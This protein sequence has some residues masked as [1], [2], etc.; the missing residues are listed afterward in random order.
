MPAALLAYLRARCNAP[1]LDYRA[2]PRRMTGGFDAAIFALDLE[3]APAAL[4]GP[5]VLRLFAR[6]DNP[7]RAQ[8]EGAVQSALAD[9]GYPAPRALVIETDPQALGG[10]FILMERLP[11]RVLAQGAEG[12]R[13]SRG[14]AALLRVLVRL[15]RAAKQMLALWVE[16]QRRL[17]AL[18]VDA[19]RRA[20]AAAGLDAE[21]FSFAAHLDRLAERIAATG[22]CALEPGLAWLQSH[23]PKASRP[24]VL[25]HGD[26]HPLNILSEEGRLTGVVDWS[27]L[28]I[29]DPAFDFGAGSAILATVPLDGPLQPIR[30]AAMNG[31]A[32]R[33]RRASG[34]QDDAALRY[35]QVFNALSQ[36][37]VVGLVR[38]QGKAVAGGYHTP[39]GV[40]NLT[41][42]IRKRCG[43]EI[44][45]GR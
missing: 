3:R 20:I 25:C 37:A 30:R 35:Y 41:G 17:H 4:S 29:A 26:L 13:E 18:P 21:S 10:A 27:Q 45:A 16:A 22:L 14:V 43:I 5:L 15:P 40:R 32:R 28:T 36:L 39:E 23:T 11:G 19:F 7:E 42:Y 44:E 31:L 8:R 38:A 12:L 2:P 33:Y 24:P 6:G 34:A 9:L 1:A